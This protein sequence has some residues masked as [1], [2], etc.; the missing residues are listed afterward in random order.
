MV[1]CVK[2]HSSSVHNKLKIYNI[3]YL[4]CNHQADDDPSI[5]GRYWQADC[6]AVRDCINPAF[7]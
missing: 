7:R 2:N 3:N 5:Y 4:M 1:K 6:M